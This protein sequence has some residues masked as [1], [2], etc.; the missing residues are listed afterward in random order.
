[1]PFQF[2]IAQIQGAC[3]IHIVSY[4]IIGTL[5]KTD[6]YDCKSHPSPLYTE[7]ERIYS[8]SV[9]LCGQSLW[10]PD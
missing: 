7:L 8:I 10:T 5:G 4:L 1:M 6:K 9:I 2:L 3:N